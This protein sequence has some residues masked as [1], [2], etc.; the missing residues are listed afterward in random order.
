[1]KIARAAANLPDWTPNKAVSVALDGREDRFSGAIR[2]DLSDNSLIKVENIT[3]PEPFRN[4]KAC[5]A[6]QNGNL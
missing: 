5:L 3:Q 6:G 2:P 4:A 1:L